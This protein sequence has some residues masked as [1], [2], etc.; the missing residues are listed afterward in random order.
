KVRPS[1]RQR[2]G[3]AW[4]RLTAP[5]KLFPVP[6]NDPELFTA[7][8]HWQAFIRDDPLALRQATARLLVES[9][10]LDAY[11]RFAPRYVRVPVVLFLAGRDRIIDNDRTRQFVESFAATDKEIIEYPEAHHT[12]EFEPDPSTFPTDLI[13]WLEK[14]TG[15]SRGTS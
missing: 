7:S 12:L 15:N 8:S 11:V 4:A 10:R 6:L 14:R 13:H 9:A 5:R 2:W 1:S 3:I